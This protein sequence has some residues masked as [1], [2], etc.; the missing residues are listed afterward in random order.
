[1]EEWSQGV[2]EDVEELTV[3]ERCGESEA[4]GEIWR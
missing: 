1:M 2:K 3:E 4:G